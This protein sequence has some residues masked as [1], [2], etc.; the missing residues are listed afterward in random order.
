MGQLIRSQIIG[1]AA[2]TA[3]GGSASVTIAG[4][5][6]ATILVSNGITTAAIFTLEGS[7]NG[8]DWFT[9][10]YGQGA[11]AAYTQ[12]PLTVA[13]STKALLFLPPSDGILW[14]RVNIS[15]ANANGTT[16]TMFAQDDN[17]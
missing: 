5:K 13:A 10:A 12:A 14:V 9:I 7:P 2:L 17:G 16:F 3:T 8:S 15:T 4:W 1:G 6:R 11:S